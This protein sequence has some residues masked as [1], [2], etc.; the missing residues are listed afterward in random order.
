VTTRSPTRFWLWLA[1]SAATLRP[2]SAIA[3]DDTDST[4]L[5]SPD[6]KAAAQ[7]LFDEGRSLVAHQ[8][9]AEACPKFAE[10]QRLDPG[11]GTELWLAD[12][13]ENNGQV[14]SAWASFKEAAAA[15]SLGHDKREAVAR[16]R[17][18]ALE[19]KIPRLMVVVSD[20]AASQGL[21]VRRDGMIMAST[22]WGFALPVDPGA[23]TIAASA[24][25]RV[26]WSTT[27]QVAARADTLQVT[28]PALEDVPPPTVAVQEPAA[29]RPDATLAPPSET[30]PTHDTGGVG[31]GQRLSAALLAGAGLLGIGVGTFFSFDAKSTYDAS[32]QDGRCLA[33]NQ[34]YPAGLQDRTQANQQA[35]VAT[36]AIGIG[37]AAVIS[38]GALYLFAPRGGSTSV[39]IAPDVHGGA[40]RVITA[41]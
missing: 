37:A 15:A 35:L 8:Q 14:A 22:T 9:F 23:H 3:A 20:A 13:Y 12:C 7:A 25:G 40:I 27:V 34:C 32:N 33:N 6:S 24:I 31:N 41:W 1:A 10:S 2:V 19:A 18:A 4:P 38:G 30:P 17:A 26:P 16:D 39:A 28:I 11:I 21:E 36:L 5:Q 29:V